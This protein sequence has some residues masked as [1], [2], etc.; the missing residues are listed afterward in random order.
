MFMEVEVDQQNPMQS[1]GH[2]Q[3]VEITVAQHIEMQMLT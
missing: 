1:Q 3:H 2:A